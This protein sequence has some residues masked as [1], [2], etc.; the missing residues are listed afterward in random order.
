MTG[1]EQDSNAGTTLEMQLTIAVADLVECLRE[2]TAA[3][4][5]SKFDY[6][7]VSTL[8][9]LFTLLFFKIHANAL[10]FIPHGAVTHFSTSFRRRTDEAK[11]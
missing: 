2:K 11:F 3:T 7:P 8:M 5:K 6:C 1:C 10:F 9:H 4:E